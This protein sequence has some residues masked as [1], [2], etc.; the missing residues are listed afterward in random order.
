M[1]KFIEKHINFK[2]YRTTMV[3]FLVA[4]AIIPC[5]LFL[6]ETYGYENGLLENMQMLVLFIGL[7][8]CFTSKLNKKFFS[9]VGLVITIIILRE[10]NC[11]RT[12]FFPIPGAVNAF[13]SWKDIKYGYLAHPIY[14]IY[15]ACVGIYFL[16]NKLFMDLLSIVK[17]IKL[18]IW[19]ILF[20]FSGMIIGM[21]AEKALENMVLE[22]MSEL[23]F[24]VALI[25]IV[26]LYSRSKDF[27]LEK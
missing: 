10:I 5:V 22:E 2:F 13:Y 14:G 17:N 3:S 25:S 4:L 9:F 7:F 24:Y 11:G 8:L 16:K 19:D 27:L 21:Y 26:Y 12:L 18:P 15:M 6:P 23:L 1:N 20:M